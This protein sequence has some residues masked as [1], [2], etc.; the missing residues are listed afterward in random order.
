MVVFKLFSDSGRLNQRVISMNSIILMLLITLVSILAVGLIL[1]VRRALGEDPVIE[2]IKWFT[3]RDLYVDLREIELSPAI[4]DRVVVPFIARL[5]HTFSKVSPKS[6]YKSLAEKIDFA[7]LPANLSLFWFTFIQ[8]FLTIALGLFSWIVYQHLPAI[9][10]LM[11]FL[12]ALM[13]FLAPVLYLY[14]RHNNRQRII[15]EELPETLH[16]LA[17]C[18]DAGLNV[19]SAIWQISRKKRGCLS[20]EF[21]K[22][23]Q[24][25]DSG[26]TN[27]E[28]LKA[29]SERVKLEEIDKM[30][31]LL[32]QKDELGANSTRLLRIQAK[33]IQDNLWSHHEAIIRKLVSIQNL[34]LFLC[35]NLAF[36][37]WLM[38]PLIGE[39]LAG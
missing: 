17:M 34:T 37:I 9:R 27:L 16:L 20:D 32:L 19:N 22:V 35:L 36:L 33:E 7:G 30:V 6:Q 11:V 3:D 31:S 26:K 5:I 12:F 2:R 29:L 4:T 21:Y 15:R 28:A 24:T 38:T 10:T 23:L 18:F 25:V 14:G 13:G 8:V 1:I 39:F